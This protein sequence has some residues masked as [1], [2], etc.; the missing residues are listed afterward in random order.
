M[1]K[2]IEANQVFNLGKEPH[3]INQKLNIDLD[4]YQDSDSTELLYLMSI[5]F[6]AH[7]VQGVLALDRLDVEN[8]R[9]IMLAAWHAGWK[10][11]VLPENMTQA[12]KQLMLIK[13]DVDICIGIQGSNL[14][15]KEDINCLQFFVDC[16]DDLP[17]ENDFLFWV[18]QLTHDI[19]VFKALSH[20]WEPNSV[21]LVLFTSGTTGKPKGV[22]FSLQ[23]II[24]STYNFV[25]H[26]SVRRDDC[27]LNTAALYTIAGIRYS[28]ILPLIHSSRVCVPNERIDLKNII[29]LLD[30]YQPSILITGPTLVQLMSLLSDKLA[31]AKLRLRLVLTG[32]AKLSEVHR[33]LV[34]NKL[35]IPILN[36]YGL[37]ET[38]GTVLADPNY[39]NPFMASKGSKV[40]T[41]SRLKVITSD[42]V[43]RDVGTG[44]LRVY[45]NNLLLGYL[46]EER[47][48]PIYVD[49]NDQVEIDASG[50]VTW[51]HRLH[52]CVKGSSGEWVFAEAVDSWLSRQKY[53]SDSNSILTVSD[54]QR[55][56]FNVDVSGVS[57]DIWGNWS[58]GIYV[59]LVKE[60]GRDYQCIKLRRVEQ[61]LRSNQ[62]KFESSI[63]PVDLR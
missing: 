9:L 55:V 49:T 40:F 14:L 33:Q 6:K 32:G 23:S 13:L 45:S 2:G 48:N 30:T 37:T 34:W 10:V 3:N 4:A 51:L 26:F 39:D 54:E 61:I 20:I 21:G 15:L 62:G 50:N 17:V 27:I 29:T 12:N 63:L 59:K 19:S 28:I 47:E 41:G 57:T 35:N 22:L 56:I 38:V 8:A 42:G 60:L 25:E 31:Y 44:E 53:V 52:N 43:E 11:A 36:I 46:G 24:R 58:A 1:H 16:N 7:K 18:E 5:A